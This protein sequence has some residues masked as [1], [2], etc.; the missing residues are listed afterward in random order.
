MQARQDVAHVLY[1]FYDVGARFLQQEHDDRRLA[2]GKAVVAHILYRVDHVGDV[3]QAYRRTIAIAQDHRRI[4][5]GGTG[6]V[7][8]AYLPVLVIQ[9]DRTLG[10]ICIGIGDGGAHIVE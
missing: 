8:R 6:L 7:I 5:R 2:V 10:T 3:A 1:G 9:F 4:I